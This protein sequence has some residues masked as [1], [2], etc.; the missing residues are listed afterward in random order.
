MSREIRAFECV[1]PA[2]TAKAAP[3]TF[4]LAMP[5]RIVDQ[6]DIR[7]PPGP[8]GLM[9]F[10]LTSSGAQIIPYN[11][12]AFVVANDERLTWPLTNQITSGAWALTGYNTGQYDHTVYVKFLLSLPGQPAGPGGADLIPADLISSDGAEA[13]APEPIPDTG[14]T[15]I[16]LAAVGG[17]GPAGAGFET[18]A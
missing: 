17:T 8:N 5:A 2:G 12:G 15:D 14:G 4:S 9:G 3:V 11:A 6:I 16:G 13:A 10:Q 7:I 18:G 1:I